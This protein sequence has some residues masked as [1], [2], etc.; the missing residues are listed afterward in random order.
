LVAS[1]ID[2]FGELPSEWQPKWK[3]LKL[4]TKGDF[5]RDEDRQF[6]ELRLEYKFDKRVHEPELKGLLPVVKG[7]TRFLPSDRISAS[8]ALDLIRDISAN[9]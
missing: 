2:C 5:K 6:P 8:Q 4:D 1:M 3:Q 7:L 9:T